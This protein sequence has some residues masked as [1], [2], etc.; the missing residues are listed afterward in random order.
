VRLPLLSPLPSREMEARRSRSRVRG[1]HGKRSSYGSESPKAAAGQEQGMPVKN[2]AARFGATPTVPRH[3]AG[4]GC[5]P[6]AS[7]NILIM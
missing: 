2:I 1:S 4:L 7:R 6:I 5:R 3:R